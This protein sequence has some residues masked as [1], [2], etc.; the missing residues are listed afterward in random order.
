MAQP[1]TAAGEASNSVV[2]V[3]GVKRR[4]ATPRD[5]NRVVKRAKSLRSSTVKVG[6]AFHPGSEEAIRQSAERKRIREL[7][8]EVKRVRQERADA[9]RERLKRVRQQRQY[10]ELRTLKVQQITSKAT[11]GRMSKKQIRELAKQTAM[12]KDMVGFGSSE[13]SA[14]PKRSGK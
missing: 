14:R 1:E 12:Y 4:R 6:R 5:T 8:A 11:I 10:N 9:E 13:R 7:N 3:T 2:P